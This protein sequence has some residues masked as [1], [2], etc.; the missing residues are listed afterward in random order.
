MGIQPSHVLSR[1]TR[2]VRLAVSSMIILLVLAA[3]RGSDTNQREVPRI[4]T[5]TSPPTPPLV[6]WHSYTGTDAT[7]LASIIR[8]F[9]I[10]SPGTVVESVFVSSSEFN[11][12][13]EEAIWSGAGPDVVLLPTTGFYALV[14]TGLLQPIPETLYDAATSVI[15]RSIATSATVENIIYGIP[16]AASYASLYFNRDQVEAP[17]EGFEMLL[18]QAI[19]YGL[20]IKPSFSTVS[21]FLFSAGN[22]LM[23]DTGQRLVSLPILTNYLGELSLLTEQNGVVFSGNGTAFRSGEAGIYFGTTSEYEQLHSA[24]GEQLGIAPPPRLRG[25]AWSTLLDT[26]AAFLGLNATQTA[27][28]QATDFIMFLLSPN[29]QAQLVTAENLAPVSPGES[30]ASDLRIAWIVTIEHGTPPPILP[31]YSQVWLPAFQTALADILLHGAE[32]AET[33]ER[34]LETLDESVAE[35]PN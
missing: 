11:A 32:P 25:Q 23:D 21:G 24:M 8:E 1:H 3:C 27:V 26:H 19:L 9:E 33:A 15:T 13:L 5:F 12:S 17:A 4:P 2:T 6:V 31:V 18:D 34:L 28:A 22:Q 10:S 7:I 35:P 20:L 29:S 14:Q 30:V 16:F